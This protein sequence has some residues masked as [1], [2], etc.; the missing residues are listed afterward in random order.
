MSAT[1]EHE[2][3]IGKFNVL[4]HNLE[5]IFIYLLE[6]YFREPKSAIVQIESFK[7]QQHHRGHFIFYWLISY[8]SYST[9]TEKQFDTMSLGHGS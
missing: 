8:P 5:Q 7:M 3:T 2:R 4:F 6:N 9:S 1:P